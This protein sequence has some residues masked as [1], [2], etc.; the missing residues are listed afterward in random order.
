MNMHNTIRP[1]RTAL[2]SGPAQ[3][4]AGI[5]AQELQL[6]SVGLDDNFFDLGGDS[7]AAET[8]VLAVQSRFGVK[9]Q[10]SV[11]RKRRRRANSAD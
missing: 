1:D 7:L 9:L 6:A 11:L 3:A 8:L 2:G 5:F 4:I 10:T